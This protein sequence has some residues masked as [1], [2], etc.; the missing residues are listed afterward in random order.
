MRF[1]LKK[2]AKALYD[3]SRLGGVKPLT[4][5]ET[6]EFGENFKRTNHAVKLWRYFLARG[7]DAGAIPHEWAREL[8]PTERA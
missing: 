5:G 8:M 7:A 6:K 3:A 4:A 1:I 2:N